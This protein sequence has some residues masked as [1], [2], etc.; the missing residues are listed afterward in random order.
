MRYALALLLLLAL[1]SSAQAFNSMGGVTYNVSFT[2]GDTR[3]YIDATSWRGWSLEGRWF[4]NEKLSF[5]LSWTWTTFHESEQGTWPVEGGHVTG[6]QF[7]RISTSPFLVNSHWHFVNTRDRYQ[8]YIPYLGFG[9]GA[10]WIETTHEIGVYSFEERNWHFGLAPE[11]GM[12]VN[13]KHETYLMV[14]L[15]YNYAFGSGDADSIQYIG[16]MIGLAYLE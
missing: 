6:S 14:T 4:N 5:G 13:L 3:D 7:R 15:R 2:L 9:L 8:K 16:L 11:G 1:C 10:Y 12:F